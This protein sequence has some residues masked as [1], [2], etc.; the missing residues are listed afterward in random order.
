MV[1]NANVADFP[2]VAE[3]LSALGADSYIAEPAEE[4][5]ELQTHGHRHHPWRRPGS[6]GPPR[7]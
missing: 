2:A 1:S 3:G 4:R 6:G 5:V 7:R